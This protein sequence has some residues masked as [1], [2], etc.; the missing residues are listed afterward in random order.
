M[1]ALLHFRADGT[2]GRSQAESDATIGASSDAPV[3][4]A[5]SAMNTFPAF[6]VYVTPPGPWGK[7][8]G[9]RSREALAVVEPFRT[10]SGL[11]PPDDDSPLGML[12]RVTRHP[13][14]LSRSVRCQV[15]MRKV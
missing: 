14:A 8:F 12:G 6:I 4:A 7:G 3:S 11:L 1:L 10:D 2:A 15:R 5:G 13:V 9:T